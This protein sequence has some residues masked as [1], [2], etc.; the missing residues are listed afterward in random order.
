MSKQNVIMDSQLLSTLMGCPRKSDFRF[1]MHLQAINGKSNSMECGSIFHTWAEYY[2]G[3]IIKGA[4]KKDAFDIGIAAALLY[5]QGCPTCSTTHECGHKPDEFP[6]VKNTQQQS[7]GYRIGWSYVLDTCQQYFDYYRNDHWVSLEVE[8]VK[9]E[10]LYEDEDI[11][12]MWKAK[13]DWI[14]DTNEGIFPVDH[15]TMKQRS[16]TLSL[17]NQFIGQCILTNTR[18][19]YVNKVGWQKTLKSEE[20]FERVPISYSANAL[21]EWQSVI[22]PHYARMLLMYNEVEYYPPNY[23]NCRGK[24]GDCEFVDVCKSDPEMREDELKRL[25]VV[26]KAWD[27]NNED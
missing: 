11:R 6:G 14:V 16:D 24:Y 26:G 5:I 1:N 15:K 20:K 2:Y 3:A 8:R 17:N 22:L 10:V 19:M 18:R 25:F 13:Y 21:I 27:V 12:V 23:S 4:S 7:E 9:G